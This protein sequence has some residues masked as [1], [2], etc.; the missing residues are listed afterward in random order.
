MFDVSVHQVAIRVGACLLILAIHGFAL[1]A[2]AWGLGDRGPKFD[3]RLTANPF[4]HLALIGT[5]V[6]ILVQVGWIRPIAIDP[7]ELRFGRFGLVICVLGSLGITL[8][9]VA[10]LLQLR[11]LVL[12]FLPNAFVPTIIAVLHET[13]DVTAW[14]V[15]FNLLPLPPLTG[16]HFAAAIRPTLAPLFARYHLYAAVALGAV[17]LTGM[18][19][20]VLQPIRIAIKDL[21]PGL[22]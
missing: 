14:F 7:A 9:T 2:I 13:V 1:A 6:M 20:T 19:Q 21:L 8:V 11:L 12:T 17:A 16:M 18:M 10:L 3:G 4:R 5:P 22:Y 15:L